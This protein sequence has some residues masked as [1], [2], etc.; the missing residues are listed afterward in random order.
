MK[1]AVEELLKSPQNNLKIF[2]D[3]LTVYDE[4]SQLDDLEDVFNQMFQ[5]AVTY[6]NKRAG[7]D[8]FC[9]L[10]CT[11]LTRPLAQEQLEPLLVEREVADHP[12]RHFLLPSNQVP[13]FCAEPSV[14]A[15]VEKCLRLV[16]KV[17]ILVTKI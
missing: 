4:E 14:V 3:G 17:G 1:T 12:V 10:V 2:R 8:E 13:T 15:R 11:A 5:G 7:V 6:R 16:G 9:N